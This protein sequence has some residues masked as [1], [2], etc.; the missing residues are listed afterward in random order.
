[1]RPG[2]FVATALCL[3]GAIPPGTAVAQEPVAEVR[4][5]TGQSWALRRPSLEVSYTIAPRLEE[6]P[7]EPA[8]G[9]TGAGM[10]GAR[11]A[12]VVTFELRAAPD[13]KRPP[14]LQARREVAALT[15]SR[16]GVRVHV[17]VERLASLTFV[18][19]PI[20]DHRLPPTLVPALFRYA[21]TAVLVD[22]SRI[23]ADDVNLGTM[24]FRGLAREASVDIRWDEVEVVRFLR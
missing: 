18:R 6:S 2:A 1:M 16:L 4:T 5:W 21:A 12:D 17:P 15:L 14:A 7:L 9:S 3:A 8:S 22:G 19:Q 11:R 24:V 20:V 10:F 13:T 23:E